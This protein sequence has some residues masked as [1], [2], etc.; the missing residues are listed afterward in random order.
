MI[1]LSMKLQEYLRKWFVGCS[2]VRNR[3]DLRLRITNAYTMFHQ[4]NRM[5][6]RFCIAMAETNCIFLKPCVG[7]GLYIFFLKATYYAYMYMSM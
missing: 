5:P 7:I 4:S 2:W 3:A 6:S 1:C